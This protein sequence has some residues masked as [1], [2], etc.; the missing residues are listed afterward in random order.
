MATFLTPAEVATRCNIS[1]S[2][3]YQLV[4]GGQLPCYRLGKEGRRGA[5]RIDEKDLESFLA[6]CREEGRDDDEGPLKFIK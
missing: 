3:V 5:I 1:V 6:E 2:L 4:S